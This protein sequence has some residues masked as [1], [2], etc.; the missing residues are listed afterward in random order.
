MC[1]CVYGGDQ[2]VVMRAVHPLP[3]PG[4][5]QGP[6]LCYSSPTG[7]TDGVHLVIPAEHTH[8]QQLDSYTHCVL[9]CVLLCLWRSFWEGGEFIISCNA[10]V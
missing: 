5:S 8:Q 3:E 10:S 1:V 6:T 2:H 7:H 9:V 4:V